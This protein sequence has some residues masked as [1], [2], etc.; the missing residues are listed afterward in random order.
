MTAR[1]LFEMPKF[2]RTLGED[3]K[4]P[5]TIDY[6]T[7]GN[8]CCMSDQ[9][10]KDLVLRYVLPDNWSETEKEAKPIAAKEIIEAIKNGKKVEIINAVI[11]GQFILRDINVESEITIER[12]K[13]KDIVDWSYSTFKGVL[14]LKDSIFENDAI[15][16]ETVLEKDIFL[17]GAI[18]QRKAEFSDLTATGNLYGRF[19]RR[20]TIFEKEALFNGATFKKSID[21]SHSIF[22]GEANFEN[23]RIGGD[24]EF[25]QTK[26]KQQARFNEAQI[27]G[28]VLFYGARFNQRA[29]FNGAR[30]DGNVIFNGARFNQRPSHNGAS[31]T[32]AQIKEALFNSAISCD[33]A[34]F[35]SSYYPWIGAMIGEIIGIIIAL[36]LDWSVVKEWLVGLNIVIIFGIGGAIL[37]YI[38]TQQTTEDNKWATPISIGLISGCFFGSVF[39]LVNGLNAY[40]KGSMVDIVSESKKVDILIAGLV[41]V[42]GNL[43][44]VIGSVIFGIIIGVDIGILVGVI[45]AIS[46]KIGYRFSGTAMGGM[47]AGGI[48]GTTVGVAFIPNFGMNSYV[49]FLGKVAF[50]I[51]MGVFIGGS[52]GFFS[53]ALGAGIGSKIGGD[54]V[55]WIF[56]TIAGVI[57]TILFSNAGEHIVLT[58][59]IVGIFAGMIFGII[60]KDSDPDSR[61]F[62]S[63]PIAGVVSMGIVFAYSSL[64]DTGD[65]IYVGAFVGLILGLIAGII[66]NGDIFSKIIIGL[67][68]ILGGM[69]ISMEIEEFIMPN[70]ANIP[71]FFI[72]IFGIFGIMGYLVGMIPKNSYKRRNKGTTTI[73]P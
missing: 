45:G 65:V 13:I 10:N 40:T 33:E 53:G 24:A 6:S 30:I 27:D 48:I 28:N 54:K 2:R 50:G 41:F 69:I 56:G 17:D 9:M 67:F 25:T 51:M 29:S 23:V 55:A 7:K 20:P 42:L 72:L 58:S 66:F 43:G 59:M 5:I 19:Y 52:S 34:H 62:L 12:T 49:V 26:F 11:D 71:G 63:G 57:P 73:R 32:G 46:G 35:V 4:V 61:I 68:G 47:I 14:N 3:Y 18:F 15:F 38:G 60:S 22:K 64:S 16:T 1:T 36:L 44:G 21:F 70:I 8:V 37:G 39:G 31:Y